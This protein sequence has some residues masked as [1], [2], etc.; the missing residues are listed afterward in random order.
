MLWLTDEA[1]SPSPT[2]S[3]ACRAWL[4]EVQNRERGLPLTCPSRHCCESRGNDEQ[5]LCWF[6]TWNRSPFENVVMELVLRWRWEQFQIMF[7]KNLAHLNGI[8]RLVRGQLA[9]RR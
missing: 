6:Q 4:Y 7:S 5:S 9:Q 8:R 1:V 2:R 3:M